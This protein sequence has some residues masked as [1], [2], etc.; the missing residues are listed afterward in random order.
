MAKWC[1]RDTEVLS[2]W[3]MGLTRQAAK[4]SHRFETAA[5]KVEDRRLMLKATYT[6]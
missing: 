5:M 2:E 6:R 4:G 3:G 1:F